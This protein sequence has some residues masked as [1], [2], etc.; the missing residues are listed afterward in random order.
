MLMKIQKVPMTPIMLVIIF[1]VIFFAVYSAFD[2][3]TTSN[4]IDQCHKNDGI[5]IK[6]GVDSLCL[7][8]EKLNLLVI[9]QK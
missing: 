7:S 3:I 2:G 5:Y 1:A 8:R 4:Y 9:P 6:N